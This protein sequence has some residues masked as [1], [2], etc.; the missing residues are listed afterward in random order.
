[1]SLTNA[2]KSLCKRAQRQADVPDA[3]YREAWRQITGLADCDTSTDP[4]LGNRELDKM[5]SYME[6]IYWRRID[7]RTLQVGAYNRHHPFRTRGYWSA[8]NRKI[9]TSRDRFLAGAASGNVIGLERNLSLA[10]YDPKNLEGIRR[11]MDGK[12]P[13]AHRAALQRTLNALKNKNPEEHERDTDTNGQVAQFSSCP[14]AAVGRNAPLG[15]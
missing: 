14:A 13:F 1:M 9:E 4:R 7:E 8:R 6:A 15:Q 2:Q 11:R 3:E 10:G 12:T 5:M